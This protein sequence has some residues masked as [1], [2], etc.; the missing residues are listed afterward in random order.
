MVDTDKEYMRTG[1][2][3]VVPRVG[4]TCDSDSRSCSDGRYWHRGLGD[5]RP[6]CVGVLLP[7]GPAGDSVTLP[8]PSGVNEGLFPARQGDEGTRRR[9][10]SRRNLL[11]LARRE[12]RLGPSE[13]PGM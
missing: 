10:G 5:Y 6:A 9:L 8:P 13:V 4:Q 1:S 7:L 2:S 3:R 11:V 12:G